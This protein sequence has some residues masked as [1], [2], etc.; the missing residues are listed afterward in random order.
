[1]V[2]D[3][4]EE[5]LEDG[6]ELQCHEVDLDYVEERKEEVEEREKGEIVEEKKEKRR[7]GLING[8]V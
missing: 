8:T 1:M 3:G 2:E 4:S 7:K 5:Q 6:E